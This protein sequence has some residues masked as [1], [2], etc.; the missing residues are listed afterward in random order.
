MVTHIQV[1]IFI[2]SGYILIFKRTPSHRSYEPQSLKHNCSSS[3]EIS[4]TS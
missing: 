3:S 4:H 1:A 2:D